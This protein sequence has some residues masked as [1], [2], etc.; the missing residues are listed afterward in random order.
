[1]V[2]RF[3]FDYRGHRHLCSDVELEC[4]EEVGYYSTSPFLMHS[5]DKVLLNPYTQSKMLSMVFTI[6]CSI[7]ASWL[8]TMA[9]W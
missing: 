8:M 5:S 9:E 3:E 4:M 1:M 2:L 6:P 7:P